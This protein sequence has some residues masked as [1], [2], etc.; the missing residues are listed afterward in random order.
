MNDIIYMLPGICFAVAIFMFCL[1]AFPSN[2]NFLKGRLDEGTGYQAGTIDKSDSRYALLMAMLPLAQK[3]SAKNANKVKKDTLTELS[4]QLSFAGN[5]LNIKPIEYYNMRFVGAIAGLLI[6]TLIG[7][8]LEFGL[9][10][11]LLG[12]V[13]GYILPIKIIQG[14]IKKR[15]MACEM[16]MPEA[17]DLIS[18]CM[19]SSM[20]LDASIQTVCDTSHG[21]L[22]DEFKLVLA[23]QGSGADPVQAFQ[24]LTRRVNSKRMGKLLQSVKLSHELGTPIAKQLKI[25]SDTI[26]G[27]TIEYV[28]QHAARAAALV[29][30]PAAMCMIALMLLI[31]GPMV[32]QMMNGGL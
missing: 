11:G 7:Y 26:R 23:E 25:L 27:E 29:M 21:T 17:L 12:A 2:L 22:I 13:I 14:L 6:F 18:V 19:D 8:I 16:A 15:A 3:L 9:A 4:A 30:I 1:A 10:V 32:I 20:N 5:P 28:K 24:G 31:A